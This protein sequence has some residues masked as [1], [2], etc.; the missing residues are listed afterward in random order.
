MKKINCFLSRKMNFPAYLAFIIL[1]LI[2]SANSCERQ[3]GAK[4]EIKTACYWTSP[5]MAKEQARELSKFSLV[6]VDMEN[7]VNNKASLRLIKRLNPEIKLICYSN[8]MEFFVPMIPGRSIQKRWYQ[9]A[10]DYPRWTLKRDDGGEAI[11]W[12]DMTMMNLSSLC[13][14]YNE[15]NY[16]KWMADKLLNEVLDD[17]IWDGYFLDNGGGNIS[18]LY[19]SSYSQLDIDDD[20]KKD[21]SMKI[22]EAWYQGIHSFLK[23]IRDKKGPE[24][25]LMANKG[26][27]DFMD[28][29]D[30]RLFENWVNDYLGS[31][32]NGGWDQCFENAKRMENEFGAKYT[33]FQVRQSSELE[34]ALASAALL[35]HV[36]VAVGQDNYRSYPAFDLMPGQALGPY[37]QVGDTYYRKFENF[38]VVVRPSQERGEIVAN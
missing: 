3:Q 8:P 31:K 22:D 37:W 6:I 17:P 16:P 26:S 24:F 11:F 32:V 38:K 10:L 30:G 33:I 29:L 25:I 28:L 12:I 36:Y 35:D 14:S 9:E 5:I 1:Y 19:S 18:W 2:S 27:M 7:M 20:G 13:P 4:R 34:Y 15:I 21:G 23:I